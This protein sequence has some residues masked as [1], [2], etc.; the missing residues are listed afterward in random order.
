MIV[1]AA[2]ASYASSTTASN[3]ISSTVI[4]SVAQL[5]AQRCFC[6]LALAYSTSCI[7]NAIYTWQLPSCATV[8]SH[9]VHALL[10]LTLLVH[11]LRVMLIMMIQ[12]AVGALFGTAFAAVW[13]YWLNAPA[14]AA[15]TAAVGKE[16]PLNVAVA[17]CILGGVV[18][19]REGRALLKYLITAPTRRNE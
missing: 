14:A 11:C 5:A 4:S 1:L 16:V 10:T 19:S 7:H 6:V 3:C 12:V 18:I 2:A 8:H 9:S 13:Y 15:I 17:T